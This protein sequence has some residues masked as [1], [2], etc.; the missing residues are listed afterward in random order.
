MILTFPTVGGLL[1]LVYG[2]LKSLTFSQPCFPAPKFLTQ[3]H[4]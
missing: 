1:S 2:E 3:T 4:L